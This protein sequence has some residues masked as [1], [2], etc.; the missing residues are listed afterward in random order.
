[1]RKV[2]SDG[3]PQEH[4]FGSDLRPEFFELGYKLFRDKDTLK[5][6][7]IAADIFDPTSRLSVLDG[8][9]DIIYAGSFLHLF[10]YED[11]VAICK[12]IV[13]LL[14]DKKGSLLL[15]RQVGNLEAGEHV[16]S[17]NQS[18]KM[19]RHNSESFRK[20]WDEVGEETGTKWRVETQLL[21]PEE[22]QISERWGGPWSKYEK[23]K[24]FCFSRIRIRYRNRQEFSGTPAK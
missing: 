9:V 7:F 18:Q 12:R 4:L 15:G 3:A 8:N 22:A 5:S 21:M 11:Q 10:G 24:I 17:M 20:M 19:F 13:K 1:L 14:R 23:D 16:N 6:K 2:A